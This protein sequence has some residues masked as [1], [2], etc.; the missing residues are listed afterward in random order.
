MVV[1][2]LVRDRLSKLPQN[3]TLSGQ[4]LTGLSSDYPVPMSKVDIPMGH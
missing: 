3:S 4:I 2:Y 1:R